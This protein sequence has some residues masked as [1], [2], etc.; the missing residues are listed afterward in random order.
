MKT[1][2]LIYKK[3]VCDKLREATKRRE[4]DGS[5]YRFCFPTLRKSFRKEDFNISIKIY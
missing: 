3:I 5:N 2:S 1:K 4:Q